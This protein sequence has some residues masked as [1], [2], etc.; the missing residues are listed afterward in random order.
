MAIAAYVCHPMHSAPKHGH[1]ADAIGTGPLANWDVGPLN[2]FEGTKSKT[3]NDDNIGL[4][5][6]TCDEANHEIFL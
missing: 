3:P 6:M 1:L 5:R 2:R 4:D